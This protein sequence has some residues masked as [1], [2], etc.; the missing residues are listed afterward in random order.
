M[1]GSA[2]ATAATIRLAR[3]SVAPSAAK[4][5]RHHLRD[6]PR[7]LQPREILVRKTAVDIVARG[8]GREFGH[9]T[10]E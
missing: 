4:L 3:A 1:A 2:R 7:A 5:A 6:Q 10:V 8:I 9:E